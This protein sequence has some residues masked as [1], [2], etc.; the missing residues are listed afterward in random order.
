MIEVRNVTK[1]YL[2]VTGG[3]YFVFRDLNLTIE[4]GLNVALLGRNGEGKSTLLRLLAGQ[5]KPDKGEIIC[6]KTISW[7]IGLQSVFQGSLTGRQN[8]KFVARVHGVDQA[9]IREIVRYVEDFAEIGPHF[10]MPTRTYSTGMRGRVA[11]GLSL[12]FD[13]D[14]YLIDEALSVGD[15]HFRQKASA[16]LKEKISSG[17]IILATHA[18]P[19]VK[20]M[21]DI[22]LLIKDGAIERFD[23]INA[24]I[25]AYEES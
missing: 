15:T 11:F 14:Y 19:Q 9:H 23:D 5:E 3:R 18:M 25:R 13:F 7:P 2:I 4:S 20:Q 24:G 10:D 22:V 21:C 16:A 8:V 6:S 12:A 17:N 1:S